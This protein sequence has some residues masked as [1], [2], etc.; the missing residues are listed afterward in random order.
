[1][2]LSRVCSE[3][4]RQGALLSHEDAGLL[5]GVDLSTVGRLMRGCAAEGQ[6]PPTRG[7][8]EDIGPGVSHKERVVRL[9]CR[10]LLP[11][12]IAA[13]TGH[14]LGSIERY[15]LDFARV[16]ELHRRGVSLDAISRITTMSPSL[17]RTY[18]CL[19]EELDRPA[20]APVLRRLMS[21][22]GPIEDADDGE[23]GRG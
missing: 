21:R 14:T 8:V 12:G 20:H 10:G 1:M 5:L 3:A 16:I 13:R 22:F 7:F 2:R 11:D 6:R 23:V 9:Y 19:L 17:V 4:Y 18:L 15:L